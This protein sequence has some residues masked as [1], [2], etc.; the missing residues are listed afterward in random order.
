MVDRTQAREL[1]EAAGVAGGE[2]DIT[3]IPGGTINQA[4]RLDPADGP[5]MVLRIAPS[6]ADVG[7]GPSWLTSHG[8]LREQ[9]V[10]RLLADLGDVLPRRLHFDDS[11]TLIDR[12]WVVQSVVAGQPWSELR[13]ALDDREQRALWHE[14]GELTARIHAVEGAEFGPPASWHG[15]RVWSEM[16]RWD[17]TGLAV[18]AER[19]HLDPEPFQMLCRLIDRAV[20]VLDRITRPQLI[21]SDLGLHHVFIA[22][23]QDGLHHISGLIDF[24]F[25]RF[26]DPLSE[27]VFVA[28]ELH[29]TV[30][31]DFAAFC[32]GYGRPPNRHDDDIR[33]LIYQMVA[34]GWTATDLVRRGHRDEVRTVLGTLGDLGRTLEHRV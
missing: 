30:D 2:I 32:A 6:D 21:H 27:S 8:L 13:D 29:P 18:D 12:D 3:P 28:H 9:E 5:P 20:P 33:C 11:R 24:E 19:Y 1:V 31:D 17:A 22:R 10:L 7:A 26:A 25:G 16:M 14:L 23:G 15:I 4:F 34:L